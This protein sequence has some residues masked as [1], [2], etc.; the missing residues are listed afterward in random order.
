MRKAVIIFLVLFPI[1]LMPQVSADNIPSQMVKIDSG[2]YTPF[3]RD[4]NVK[5]VKVSSFLIDKYPVSNREYFEFVKANPEWRKTKVKK[6]FADQYYLREWKGDLDFGNLSADAPVTYVSWFAARAY[7]EWKGKRLPSEAEWEYTGKAGI[8]TADGTNEKEYTK[9]ILDWYSAPSGK[10]ADKGKGTPNYFGL[11]DMHGLIWEWVDDFNTTIVTG[12]SRGN[13]GLE[14]NLFCGSGSLRSIDPQNYA[15]FLRYAFRS[16]L[17]A[18]YT[19][20]N[21]GFRCAKD[22]KINIAGRN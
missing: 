17:K 16:S 3:F 21:L 2:E 7:S 11:Y 20:G 19:V 5:K 13:T 14:R 22:I 1:Y 4:E 10:L 8:K 18:N 6:I 12:E 9:K 15:A